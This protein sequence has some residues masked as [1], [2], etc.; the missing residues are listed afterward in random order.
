MDSR[1]SSQVRSYA[2]PM[3]EPEVLERIAARRPEMDGL[4][5]LVKRAWRWRLQ[6]LCCTSLLYST[7]PPRV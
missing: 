6:R 5:Q 4:E 7:A 2:P 3:M 1:P